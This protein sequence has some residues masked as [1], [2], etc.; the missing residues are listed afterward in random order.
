MKIAIG[1]LSVALGAC[2]A[3]QADANL[4]STHEA[5]FP[6]PSGAST[7]LTTSADVDVDVHDT[8]ESIGRVGAVQIAI[9][10][11]S[12][13]GADLAFVER[14][15]ATVAASDGTLPAR[16]LADFAVPAGS[17][18]VE[19]QTLT[20]DADLA[21]YLRE[22]K[23]VVHFVL[24]GALPRRP[25]VLTHEIGARVEVSVSTSVDKLP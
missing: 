22:G 16:A 13:A 15:S 19:I 14:I 9:S 2:V 20:S 12:L 18:R 1:I 24:S 10:R 3:G 25:L 11:D 4:T 5:S 6:A 23:V 8:I 21:A 17:T 7:S